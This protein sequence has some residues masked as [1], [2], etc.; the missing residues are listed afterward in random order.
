MTMR[1]IWLAFMICA[2][3]CSEGPTQPTTPPAAT[4]PP[5]VVAATVEQWRGLFDITNCSG[6]T[7][8]CVGPKTAEFMLTLT[9]SAFGLEGVLVLL[10]K[11]RTTVSVS[12]PAATGAPAFTAQG[13]SVATSST[14]PVRTAVSAIDLRFDA[15]T[16]I[17]GSMTYTNTTFRSFSRTIQFR[18]A[19]R[20]PPAERPGSVHGTWEGYYRT[21]SCT[22]E[23]QIGG[24]GYNF[25]TGGTL[26]MA[27]SATGAEFIGTVMSH[28]VTGTVQSNELQGTGAALTADLC[29]QCW[30]CEGVC[31]SAVRSISA[32]V[33]T[34]GRMTGTFEYSRKGWTGRKDEHFRQTMIVE[35]VSVTRRW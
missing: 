9:G 33:D 30:D 22:G 25:P 14:Y 12:A 1:R 19:L 17:T 4:P 16:G 29:Q 8:D 20:L 6:Q 26:A 32:R 11:E 15:A 10:D 23:C 18:S 21:L 34:L 35:I 27:F 2:A 31:Q 3:A 5:T 28:A 13:Y 7:G 24:G